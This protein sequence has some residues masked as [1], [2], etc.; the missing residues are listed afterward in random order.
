MASPSGYGV[1]MWCTDQIRS[2]RRATGKTIVG[3]ALYRRLI[4]ERGSLRGGDEEL[5]Y[6]ID[7]P[8]YIGAVGDEVALRALPPLIRGELLKDDRVSDVAVVATT[9]ADS[10]GDIVINIVID[11]TLADSEETFSLTLAASET[12]L[13]LLGGVG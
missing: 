13:V 8:G 4:T 10:S 5:A 1:G 11:V 3:H 9:A 12:S 7:L 2:G 6:G